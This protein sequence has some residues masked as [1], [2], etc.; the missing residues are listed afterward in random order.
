MWIELNMP[1]SITA[2]LE[3]VDQC[4]FT[5]VDDISL[6]VEKKRTGIAGKTSA[7]SVLSEWILLEQMTEHQCTFWAELMMAGN[8]NVGDCLGFCGLK[9]GKCADLPSGF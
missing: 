4:D 8:C 5:T 3:D 6:V 1:P 9:C 2:V 7:T